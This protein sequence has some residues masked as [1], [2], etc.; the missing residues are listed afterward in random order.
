MAAAL[1]VLKL[2]NAA[3]GVDARMLFWRAAAC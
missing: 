1:L 2:G 3:F